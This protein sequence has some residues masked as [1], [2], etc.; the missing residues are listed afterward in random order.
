MTYEKGLFAQADPGNVSGSTIERKKMSTKTIYK[1]IALVAVA[2]LGAGVLS[3][4]PASATFGT[5][6]GSGSPA[7]ATTGSGSTPSTQTQVSGPNN[8]V[9]FSTTATAGVL[10]IA[11]STLNTAAVANVSLAADRLSASQTANAIAYTVPTRTAGTITVNF[12]ATTNGA[13]SSTASDSLVITVVDSAQL[14]VSPANSTSVIAKGSGSPTTANTDDVVTASN[15]NA[16]AQA[17]NI[18]VTVKNGVGTGASLTTTVVSATI[19]GPGLLGI[20]STTAAPTGRFV[21]AGGA[22]GSA[23]ITV[24]PDNTGV[25]GTSTVRIFSGS[26]L[27]ATE[28]LRLFGAVKTLASSR[29]LGA[30]SDA[31]SAGDDLFAAVITAVD[32]NAIPH[33]LT[34]GELSVSAAD[35]T[36]AGI[37]SVSFATAGGSTRT[38]SGVSVS[39]SAVVMSV[40]PTSG[41]TGSKSVTVTHTDPVTSVK[42]TLA[43]TFVVSKAKAATAVLTTDKATYTPGEKI[44]LT[45]TTKEAGALATADDATGTG[46]LATNGIT[47]NVLLAGDSTSG[48]AVPTVAGVKTWTLYAPLAPGPLTFAGKTGSGTNAPTTAVT[49]AASAL[50]VDSPSMQAVTAL[51][52]SLV[53]KIN[54]LSKLVAKIQKKVKA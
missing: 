51:I 47:A 46:L 31:S 1:R 34:P 54:A 41:K 35:V 7:F 5:I 8:F 10:T 28:T 33:T 36:A 3:V 39:S 44:T 25:G 6:L 15:L 42:T 24:W 49:L 21:V 19:D 11:G 23:A 32:A 2:A 16:A 22:S 20:G 37:A 12:F 40:T 52:N 30:I 13:T 45:L 27:I 48:T 29:V 4:A 38:I 9:S 43:V 14:L 18:A 53:A 26:T 50:V 17:A